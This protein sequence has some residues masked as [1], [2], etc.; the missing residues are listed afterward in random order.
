MRRSIL[1]LI[2]ITSLLLLTVDAHALKRVST[3][4]ELRADIG[5]ALLVPSR[6]N[7]RDVYGSGYGG[8]LALSY[9]LH[10]PM[11]IGVQY[12]LAKLDTD[13]YGVTDNITAHYWGL[14]VGGTALKNG[15]SEL[16]LGAVIYLA[17]AR[18]SIR[19]ICQDCGGYVTLT[20]DRTGPGL[21]LDV[22][23]SYLLT[24]NVAVGAEADYIHTYLGSGD[25]WLNNVGGFWFGMFVSFRM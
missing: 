3:K 22:A 2:S 20:R 11:F 15:N 6:D 12:R 5:G 8:K 19:V 7:L 13:Q 24:D 9:R 10:S 23:Y 21:G 18:Q 14:K 1:V 25:E 17:Y 4:G 16:M